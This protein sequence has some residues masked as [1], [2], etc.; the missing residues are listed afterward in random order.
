MF[1]EYCSK[2]LFIMYELYC[3]LI[4]VVINLSHPFLIKWLR[5]GGRQ[6]YCSPMPF[7]PK[8]R[9]YAP[10]NNC[11]TSDNVDCMVHVKMEVP[12]HFGQQGRRC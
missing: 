12:F 6:R 10:I 11:R 4:T 2:S 8:G 5:E 1:I 9:G 3:L 7:P